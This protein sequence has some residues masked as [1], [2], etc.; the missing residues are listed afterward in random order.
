MD[1]FYE[2][3]RQDSFLDKLT[4]ADRHFNRFMNRLSWDATPSQWEDRADEVVKEYITVMSDH[5][6]ELTPE[7]LMRGDVN[8]RGNVDP[9]F[10][11]LLRAIAGPQVMTGEVFDKIRD[12]WCGSD[13]PSDVDELIRIQGDMEFVRAF[14]RVRLSSDGNIK[15]LALQRNGIRELVEKSREKREGK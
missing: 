14:E 10:S 5:M 4:L 15:L 11:V 1:H 3:S 8:F 12:S 7:Y 13:L 6:D 9:V 2:E